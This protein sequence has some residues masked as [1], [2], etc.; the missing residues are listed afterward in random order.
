ME[1]PDQDIC[2][3]PKSITI[4]QISHFFLVSVPGDVGRFLRVRGGL[5]RLRELLGTLIFEKFII[6]YDFRLYIFG[7]K[8]KFLTKSVKLSRNSVLT[9]SKYVIFYGDFGNDNHFA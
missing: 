4:F 1:M 5:G 3:R 6:S 7:K 2:F 9:G 8:I